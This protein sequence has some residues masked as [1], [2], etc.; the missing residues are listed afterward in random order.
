MVTLY[1][2]VENY[3]NFSIFH[4]FLAVII[5]YMICKIHRWTNGKWVMDKCFTVTQRQIILVLQAGVTIIQYEGNEVALI[6]GI[7]G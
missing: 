7:F 5:H 3:L 4:N 1:G 6:F 2:K